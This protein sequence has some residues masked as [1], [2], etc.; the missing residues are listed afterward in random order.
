MI[1]KI[2]F[3]SGALIAIGVAYLSLAPVPIDPVSWQPLSDEGHVGVFAPNT[4]LANLSLIAV[5]ES[6]GPEDVTVLNGMLYAT[7]QTGDITRIDPNTKT[8]S[9]VANT[10]GVP[11]GIEA[12]DS[13]IYIADAH[14]G[15]L[16]LTP[17]G[18]LKTLTDT[19]DGS[20][21][22]YADDLDVSDDGVIYFSDAS[23]KFGA[24][25]NG[26]TMAASLLEIMES[27]GTGRVLAFN[28]R[29]QQTSVIADGL[30][31]PNGVAM[32]PDGS[33]LVNETGRYR[34]LKIDPANGRMTDW[35]VN[36]PG[37]PDNI[38]R[39]PEGTFFVG[40]IS[41]RSAWLDENAAKPN[42]RKVAMR[43][44]P[45]MRPQA[46]H[47]GHIVQLDAGGNVL[48]TFQDPTGAYHDATGAIVHEG[49]LYVTSLHETDLAYRT[50]PEL[51]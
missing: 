25:A 49:I 7:S 42:M 26:K 39:G 10:G 1:K 20:P 29:T 22:L 36:M 3:G 48:R 24:K 35:I 5:G 17:D 18:T 30:V 34:V 38:N 50:Y 13:V 12:H 11:L 47:Y 27:R 33:V 45:S 15:L 41:P 46:Q 51:N 19:V 28:L 40:L 8:V 2:L 4:E 23:T 44:P 14:K 21:I 16:S 32:H 9:V 6:I 43:L 31:F 37:F